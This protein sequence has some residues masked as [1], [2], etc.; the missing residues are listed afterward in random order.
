MSDSEGT[1]KSYP[2]WI[3]TERDGVPVSRIVN[4]P[5]ELAAAGKGWAESPNGPFL[6]AKVELKSRPRKRK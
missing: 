1:H 3:Y 2:K 5:R 4:D 6:T